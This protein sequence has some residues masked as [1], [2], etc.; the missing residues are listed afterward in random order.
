LA[1]L[2][3]IY[4]GIRKGIERKRERRRVLSPL[5]PAGI[6]KGIESVKKEFYGFSAIISLESGKELKD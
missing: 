3:F 1:F 2:A 6:R 5:S 4:S